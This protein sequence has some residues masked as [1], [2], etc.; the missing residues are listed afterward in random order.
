MAT[1]IRPPRAE[2]PGTVLRDIAWKTYLQLRDNP[3]NYHTRMSYL[4]GTLILMSPEYL[5]DRSRRR[6]AM[7]VDTVAWVHRI[8]H[9]GTATTTLR[10]KGATPRKGSRQGARLR[11]L[12]PRE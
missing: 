12:F 3:S 10:R 7:V 9:Q 4:D 8:P 1:D 11:I 2:A 5:H 6:L